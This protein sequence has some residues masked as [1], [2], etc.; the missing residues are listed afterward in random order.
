MLYDLASDPDEQNNLIGSDMEME[1][2]M[3]EELLQ[4]F[5]SSQHSTERPIEDLHR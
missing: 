4:R 2:R 3:K 1:S 5:I